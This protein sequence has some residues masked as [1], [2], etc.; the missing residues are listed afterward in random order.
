MV[1]TITH[2]AP[3]GF[4]IWSAV[5]SLLSLASLYFAFRNLHRGRLIE[6]TPTSVSYTHLTL[7][8]IALV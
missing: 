6:D 8:T 2:M 4:W 1:D 5:L 7:P 3:S